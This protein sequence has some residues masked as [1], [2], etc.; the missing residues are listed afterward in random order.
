MNVCGIVA[1]YNPFHNGHQYHIE[2]ARRA[3]ATHIVA[4]M[5]GNFVQRAEPAII[6]KFERARLAALGGA[7]LVVEL[8]V[9]YAT[10]SSERFARGAVSL[11]AALGCVD[12][13]SF[14][15]ECADLPL[16]RQT[17]DAVCDEDVAR[18]T[19]A[20]CETG[21]SYPAAREKVVEKLYGEQISAVLRT[22]NNILAVEYLK[23][24][25]ALQSGMAV[26][27][28]AREGVLHDDERMAGLFASAK[29]LREQ[30]RAGV[31]IINYVPFETKLALDKAGAD[32][33]LSGGLESLSQ[34]ILF[35]LRT[36][37]Q[38]ELE[39]LPD[40]ADGL[41]DRLYRATQECGELGAVM[42]TAKTKRYTMSRVRRAVVCALIGISESD[43]FPPP[44]IRLLA[45][46]RYGEELLTKIGKSKKLPMSQSLLALLRDGEGMQQV[47][48]AHGENA[49]GEDDE[50]ARS[51][52][53][54]VRC[55]QL[56][57]HA[58]DIYNL[59]LDR[60]AVRG[61]DYTARFFK[62]T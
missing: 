41:G 18:L 61:R 46:G 1:E 55:A 11:L 58:T 7:D 32:G 22:P 15:C 29:S 43:F 35:R 14:G 17:A 13:I 31:D 37:T 27:P 19:K 36:M 16:L 5:S 59:S 12:S 10:G 47:G 39:A 6:S 28:V 3:G 30:V 40:C 21:M 25:R 42:E 45:V 57:A 48:R 9:Q 20:F 60:P 51:G 62:V 8:P 23:A 44:Y 50:V 52:A 34:A 33:K 26:L 2:Q 53:R 56:E 38:Q 4:V 49:A 24:L 54:M